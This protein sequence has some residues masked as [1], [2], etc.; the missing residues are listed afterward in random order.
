LGLSQGDVV[1]DVPIGTAYPPITYLGRDTWPRKG[2]DGKTIEY[3]PQT[4]ALEPFR[5]DDTGLYIARGKVTRALVVSHSCELDDKPDV[6]RVLLAPAAP[7][8]QITDQVAKARI[9]EQK[10]RA[11][12][13]LPELPELGD[14]YADLRCITYVDRKLVADSQREFS[15]SEEG[16]IRLR[17]QLIE[18]LTRLDTEKLKGDIAAALASER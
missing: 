11:L 3:R 6:G 2:K 10:R 8:S 5:T 1:R 18:F 9:L 12:L 7:L 15:M 17:A 16:V 4:K 13:P 14:Y